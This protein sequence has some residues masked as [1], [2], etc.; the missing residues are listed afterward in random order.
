MVRGSGAGPPRLPP[1]FF[2]TFRS[3]SAPHLPDEHDER[4]PHASP[5][6]SA[7]LRWPSLT[8]A[9]LHRRERRA[10][11]WPRLQRLAN[12]VPTA[13]RLEFTEGGAVSSV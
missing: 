10:C 3:R 11:L 7:A 5:S 8:L 4:L 13:E 2:C 12:P 1:Q 6:H 9:S